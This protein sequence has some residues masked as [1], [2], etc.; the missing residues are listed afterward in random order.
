MA[1]LNEIARLPP[2]EL[3]PLVPKIRSE[4]IAIEACART[5]SSRF[6]EQRRPGGGRGPRD[7]WAVIQWF[8]IFLGAKVHRALIG[9]VEEDDLDH[10]RSRLAR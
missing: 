9:F 7:P 1:E 3:E 8:Q 5:Y 10:R 2:E 4:H 6:C